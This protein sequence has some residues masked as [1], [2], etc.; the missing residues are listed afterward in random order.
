MHEMEILQQL[1]NEKKDVPVWDLTIEMMD[2]ML[3]IINQYNGLLK[4]ASSDLI[5]LSAGI[6]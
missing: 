5:S 4:V 6:I 1:Y 2:Q 3:T